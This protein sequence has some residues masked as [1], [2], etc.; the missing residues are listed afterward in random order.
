M[1]KVRLLAGRRPESMTKSC[2]LRSFPVA[3]RSISNKNMLANTIRRL[4]LYDRSS[5]RIN[6]MS[7]PPSTIAI[8][9]LVHRCRELIA[10]GAIEECVIELQKAEV[11]PSDHEFLSIVRIL[12]D[13]KNHSFVV[14]VLQ[15][16]K[17]I[18]PSSILIRDE[19]VR[20]LF[21]SGE[22]VSA[23]V[24]AADMQ[25]MMVDNDLNLK[26]LAALY[27]DIQAPEFAVSIMGQ[28]LGA[29][30]NNQSLR[31]SYIDLL[32]SVRQPDRAR[33]QIDVLVKA[34]N[35]NADDLLFAAN[36]YLRF[37]RDIA[38]KDAL[39]AGRQA[40]RMKHK[41]PFAVRAV[42]VQALVRLNRMVDAGSEAG[43]M[44]ADAQTAAD[45]VLLGETSLSIGRHD[46]ALTAVK[47]ALLIDKSSSYSPSLKIRT[48]NIFS[49]IG[50]SSE[51]RD[52]LKDIDIRSINAIGN[53]KAFHEACFSIRFDSAAL[54][55]ARRVLET[56]PYND[57]YMRRVALLEITARLPIDRPA[58]SPIRI[59]IMGRIF[60]ALKSA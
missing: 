16:A 38:A 41:S 2:V 19:L 25:E 43:H 14:D 35:S 53:V 31:R 57:H 13:A 11:H 10:Q 60:N 30:L 1:G 28:L 5:C 29:D 51:A 55:S 42:I 26:R 45:F 12:G 34:E 32:F 40:L 18:H 47:R 48:A 56:D 37:P 20:A 4:S 36:S 3:T 58:T 6:T 9:P 52:I 17:K 15:Q 8:S 54:A 21:A 44:I 59:G 7:L 27:A 33:D 23:R 46:Q 39:D 50:R 49:Q 22:K 24:E